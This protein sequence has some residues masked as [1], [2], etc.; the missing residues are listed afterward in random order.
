VD[1][2]AHVLF[3]RPWAWLTWPAL[4]MVAGT[5]ARAILGKTSQH[6]AIVPRTRVGLVGVVTAPFLH[7]NAAHL[8]ANLPP[9]LVLGALVLRHGE[10]AF[11]RTAIV[12]ALGSGVLVWSLARSAAHMGMSGVIFG[13]FGHLLALAYLTQSLSNVAI[14]A[15]VLVVYGS[16]LAGLKPARNGTSFEAH[17]F[18]LIVGMASAW[19]RGM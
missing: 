17:L 14:A 16:M 8:A 1:R 11:L 19:L 12:I 6:L 4:A 13:F 2:V 3:G 5:L 9:F 7:A 15:A 18:G 10:H